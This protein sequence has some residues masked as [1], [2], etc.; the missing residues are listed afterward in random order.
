MIN[1]RKFRF[2]FFLLIECNFVVCYVFFY[3][4]RKN[5]FEGKPSSVIDDETRLVV[6]CERELYERR[7]PSEDDYET[8]RVSKNVTSNFV[9]GKYK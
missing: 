3:I 9:L 4:K 8:I 2:S 7:P 1:I 5:L 6:E